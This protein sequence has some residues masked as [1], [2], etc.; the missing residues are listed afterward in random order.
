MSYGPPV[1]SID[2][3][4]WPQST[5]DHLVTASGLPVRQACQAVGLGRATYYRPGVDWARRDAPVI[6]ALTTLGATSGYFVSE[7]LWDR[8]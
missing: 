3:E 1:I 6:E 5:W 7:I 2:V 8:S 4:D